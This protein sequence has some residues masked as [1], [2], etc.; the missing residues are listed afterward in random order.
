MKTK[1]NGPEFWSCSSLPQLCWVILC[2]TLK[3][4]FSIY[5][6]EIIQKCVIIQSI[7]TMIAVFSLV[8][9]GAMLPISSWKVVG[10]EPAS[11]KS[12]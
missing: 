7:K 11:G 6:S 8:H 5:N 4:S 10:H 9:I 12:S 1:I 3:F 2:K